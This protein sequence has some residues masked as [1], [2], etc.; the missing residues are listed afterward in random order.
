M[1]K[2]R[3]TVDKFFGI[4]SKDEGVQIPWLSN[5]SSKYLFE[6]VNHMHKETL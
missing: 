5:L 4:S 6:G 1:V 3:T 2:G